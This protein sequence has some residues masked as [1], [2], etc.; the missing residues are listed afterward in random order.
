MPRTTRA[1]SIALALV[2]GS[3][4]STLAEE[5]PKP[6][7]FV[8]YLFGSPKAV[9]Y[10]LYT[11]VCHAFVTAGPD[12][13]LNRDR[14]VPSREVTADAH[15]AGAKVLLSLGGWGWDA[16]FRAM[17]AD[18]E[19]VARYVAAVLKMV[20]EYDYDGV[21]LDWEYPDSD[22]EIP[23]FERLTRTFRARLD[24]MGKAKGRPMLVTMAASSNHETLDHLNTAFL[25]ETMDWINVMTY[26]YAGP[27]SARAGHNSP[28]FDSSKDGPNARSSE[29]T[30]RYLLDERKI[31]ADRLALGLALYGRGFPVSEPYA[32]VPEGSEPI[33]LGFKGVGGLLDEGWTRVWDDETK[34]PWLFSPDRTKVVGY[35]DAE[36]IRIKTEWA[37]SRGLRGVFFWQVDGDRLP[38]GSNPLQR[39]AR[40]AWSAGR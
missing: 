15:K 10:G 34:V 6:R 14:G 35:D 1:S 19:A 5:V 11:H 7:E 31:P 40:E 37:M 8:G 24:E 25:L 22:A 20:D 9:N 39:A 21:D 13:R 32:S 29:R 28:L 17:V 3:T 30:I 33:S 23:G 26:D 36:S 4:A 2:L 16:Q 18:P 12:G 38:D 27:W